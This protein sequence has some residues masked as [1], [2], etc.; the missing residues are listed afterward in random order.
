MNDWFETEWAGVAQVFRLRRNVQDGEKAREETVYGGTNLLKA[1]KT[2]PRV[3]SP[4]NKPI[5]VSKI[6]CIIAEMSY[7]GKMR[8]RCGLPVL[9]TLCLPLM[10]WSSP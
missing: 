4:C 5:G 3:C 2:T 8:A 6:G 1:R 7:S 10:E 9:L